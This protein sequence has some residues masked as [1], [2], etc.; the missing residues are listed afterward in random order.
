[1][2]ENIPFL[3]PPREDFKTAPTGTMDLGPLAMAGG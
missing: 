3:R 1:M 2:I